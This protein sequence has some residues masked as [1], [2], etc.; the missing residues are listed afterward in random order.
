MLYTGIVEN[1][2][3]AERIVKEVEQNRTVI[4]ELGLQR[5]DL[6]EENLENVRNLVKILIKGMWKQQC[7][8]M[9]MKEQVH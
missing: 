2:E 5:D 9:D 4:S 7:V 1:E 3:V 8:V 6:A